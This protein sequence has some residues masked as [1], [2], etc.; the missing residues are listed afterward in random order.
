LLC[1]GGGFGRGETAAQVGEF[2]WLGASQGCRSGEA[3]TKATDR[4]GSPQC[5]VPVQVS[6]A[7]RE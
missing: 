7:R 3:E 1:G 2:E 5:D 6:H 4:V